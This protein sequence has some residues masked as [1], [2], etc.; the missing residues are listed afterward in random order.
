MATAAMRPP[1]GRLFFSANEAAAFDWLRLA[2]HAPREPV[3]MAAPETGLFLPAWAGV[4]VIYGHPFETLDAAETRS[5]VEGFFAGTADRTDM[6]HGVD[7]I[8][9]GPREKKLGEADPGWQPVFRAGDVT[10]YST[11]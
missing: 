5:K 6:L 3:V 2:S 8:F 4:R 9:F 11:P 7:Y 10:I 1:D